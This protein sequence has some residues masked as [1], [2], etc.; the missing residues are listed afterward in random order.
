MK[1][2]FF[3]AFLLLLLSFSPAW[4]DDTTETEEDP[5][6]ISEDEMFSDSQTVEEVTEFQDETITDE[7]DKGTYGFSGILRGSG[8]YRFATEKA[9]EDPSPYGHDDAYSATVNGDIFF[10]A[11]WKYGIKF[12]SD[13]YLTWT[14]VEETGLDEHQQIKEDED[15]DLIVREIF[16]DVNIAQAVYFRI[17]K[18][19]LKW[20]RGYFWNPTDLISIDKKDFNDVDALREGT[21]GLKI[22][23]PFGTALNIY[24]FID[25]TDTES[26]DE[27]AFAGKIE[28]LVLDNTEISLSGWTKQDY[29]PVYGIDFSTHAVDTQWRGEASV[30][31]GGNRHFLVKENEVWVDSYDPEELIVQYSL[32][33]TKKFDVG[34]ITDRLSLTGEFLIN[35]KGY[36]ENM[37]ERTPLTGPNGMPIPG[38]TLRELFLSEYYRPYYYGKYYAALFASL[39]HLAGTS[40]L[41]LSANSISNLSDSSSVLATNLSYNVTFDTTLTFSILKYTGPENREFT[42]A[43]NDTSLEASFSTNY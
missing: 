35:P 12:F 38:A 27:S 40:D 5:F 8:I 18:Q 28:F 2:R 30:S 21:Y 11:R 10:D 9:K 1:I 39:S 19:T 41:T 6:A 14:P 29:K 26:Y 33:F 13:V 24:G 36:D 25:T 43:G 4:A 7:F 3:A 37:L 22:Q 15:Y 42:F 31:E 16:G 17:G 20:G 34:D 23:V 32:G